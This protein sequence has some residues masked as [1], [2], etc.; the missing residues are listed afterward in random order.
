MIKKVIGW[1]LTVFFIIAALALTPVSGSNVILFIAGILC[2]PTLTEKIKGKTEKYTIGI[3]YAIITILF[4]IGVGMYPGNKTEVKTNNEIAKTNVVNTVEQ[5]QQEEQE[6]AKQEQEKKELE[7][8]QKKEQEIKQQEEL[9]KAEEEKK[10]QEEQQKKEEAEKQAQA[11]AKQAAAKA[12]KKSA[13]STSSTQSNSKIV[14]ITKTGGKYHS[15]GCRYLKKSSISTTLSSA[16][17][18]GYSACSV[19]KP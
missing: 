16:L 13:S 18:Q 11:Q 8:K 19:C 2:I 14:Y 3:Q 17:A 12:S 7:E 5:K 6:R 15:A 4:I 10:A 1:V 9:K